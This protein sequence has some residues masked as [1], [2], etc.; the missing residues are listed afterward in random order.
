VSLLRCNEV[1][2]VRRVEDAAVN[3]NPHYAR[4]WP[5]PSTTYL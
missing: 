5:E 3:T 2:V 4:I 1:P